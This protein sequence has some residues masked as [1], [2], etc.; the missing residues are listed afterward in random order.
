LS[1]TLRVAGA[2]DHTDILEVLEEVAPEVPVRLDTPDRIEAIKS[3]IVECCASGDS[4]VAV[5]ETGRVVGFVL[6]KPDNME[7]FENDNHAISLRYIGVAKQFRGRGIFGSLMRRYIENEDVLTATV[8]D[9]NQG[10]MLRRLTDLGFVATAKEGQTEL[11]LLAEN[12]PVDL[13]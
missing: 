5:D 13:V 10:D 9:G 6:A 1:I 11:K 7:R 2:D 3:I 12:S 8:L 4:T